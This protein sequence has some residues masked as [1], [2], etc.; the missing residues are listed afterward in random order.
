MANLTSGLSSQAQ[1]MLEKISRS[2]AYNVMTGKEA[3]NFD[4]LQN[5]ASPSLS[6]PAIHRNL[7]LFE[8]IN[9]YLQKAPT[10]DLSDLTRSAYCQYITDMLPFYF[11]ILTLY[12]ECMI[13]LSEYTIE[14]IDVYCKVMS[15]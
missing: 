2:L 6:D 1:N 5:L 3:P 15:K 8:F 10:P 7:D 4:L 14:D 9:H 12:L 11:E 13:R